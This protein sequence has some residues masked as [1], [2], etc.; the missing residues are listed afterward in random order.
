MFRSSL[1]FIR[2][3]MESIWRQNLVLLVCI[4][5]SA[6]TVKYIACFHRSSLTV[7]DEIVNIVRIPDDWSVSIIYYGSWLDCEYT[8]PG[9]RILYDLSVSIVYHG[10]WSECEYSQACIGILYGMWVSSISQGS[11]SDCHYSQSCN[12]MLYSRSASITSDDNWWDSDF[13]YF[14]TLKS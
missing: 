6:L 11:L 10:N 5:D 1:Y 7:I 13:M 3:W 14:Y 2:L 9:I 8:Q 12:Q 4:D